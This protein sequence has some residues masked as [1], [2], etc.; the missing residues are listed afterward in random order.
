[1]KKSPYSLHRDWI[2]LGEKRGMDNYLPTHVFILFSFFDFKMSL[3]S[4]DR[5]K[6]WTTIKVKRR[7]W[8]EINCCHVSFWHRK[9]KNTRFFS[10]CLTSTCNCWTLSWLF[11][12][13]K[14]WLVVLVLW[15]T[16]YKNN[17]LVCSVNL[18]WNNFLR[19]PCQCMIHG[20][21]AW[22]EDHSSSALV[23]AISIYFWC[24]S[25]N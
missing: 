9:K 7:W 6:T 4:N 18:I 20:A 13:I 15:K 12:S 24:Y 16:S 8:M 3:F 11:H 25:T 1:M 5:K 21:I 14:Y 2:L 19:L 22:W 23:F 17:A 10:S